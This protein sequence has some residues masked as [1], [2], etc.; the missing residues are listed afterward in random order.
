MRWTVELTQQAARTLNKMDDVTAKRIRN[1]I[2]G[3]AALDDPIA[4]TQVEPLRGRS[5]AYRL[6]VADWRVIFELHHGRLVILVLEVGH[7]SEIYR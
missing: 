5:K 7:R 3:L 1:K 4:A 2:D 6:R